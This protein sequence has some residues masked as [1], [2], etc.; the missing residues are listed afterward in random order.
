MPKPC[1]LRW[2]WHVA[3]F[4]AYGP[5][6]AVLGPSCCESGPS[7]STF[8]T[9]KDPKIIPK[10]VKNEVQKWDPKRG[11]NTQ[12]TLKNSAPFINF[13]LGLGGTFGRPSRLY[14]HIFDNISSLHYV[15]TSFSATYDRPP[16]RLRL[17]PRFR[18][19]GHPPTPESR[20]EPI[21]RLIMLGSIFASVF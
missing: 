4:A 20:R 6:G 2:F 21:L 18:L 10:V 13:F 17:P 11:R 14:P 3:S 16:L 8:G 9:Q 15:F 5:L 19:R 12:P 7:G 1:V